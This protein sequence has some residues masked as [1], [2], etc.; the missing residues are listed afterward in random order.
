MSKVSELQSLK[1][2]IGR[3]IS[4]TISTKCPTI[5]FKFPNNLL[6]AF[7]CKR[8]HSN[9]SAAQF[10]LQADVPCE[11]LMMP[12]RSL[13][14]YFREPFSVHFIQYLNLKAVP[15]LSPKVWMAHSCPIRVHLLPIKY[16]FVNNEMRCSYI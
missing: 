6:P 2:F 5:R 4:K 15:G 11:T 14:T 3:G 12:T 7:R 9:I 10:F 13:T 1:T 8:M 16:T